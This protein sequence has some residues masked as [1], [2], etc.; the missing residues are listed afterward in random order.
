[1]R[2]KSA[3][4]NT[5]IITHTHTTVA[6]WQRRQCGGG[7]GDGG[8]AVGQLHAPFSSSSSLRAVA[9]RCD[10]NKYTLAK[11]RFYRLRH[12]NLTLRRSF[13]APMY[14]SRRQ[15]GRAM[16]MHSFARRAPPSALQKNITRRQ[17]P[18][19]QQTRVARF[20]RH[21]SRRNQARNMRYW[22]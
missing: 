2:V 14:T 5:I 19:P 7:C 16:T 22:H 13:A 15:Y 18:R 11:R 21:N 9:K 12:E 10:E 17:K 8:A 1:M 6:R 4:D 20:S 3:K